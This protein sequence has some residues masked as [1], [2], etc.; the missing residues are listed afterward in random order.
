MECKV[1]QNSRPKCTSQFR[2]ALRPKCT[3]QFRCASFRCRASALYRYVKIPAYV[4]AQ[5]W[6]FHIPVHFRLKRK[7]PL[8]RGI[9]RG[10]KKR[11]VFIYINKCDVQFGVLQI[12]AM[13]LFVYEQVANTDCEFPLS[14]FAI[15][16]WVVPN[17]VVML[18]PI[19]QVS[20][21]S[22]EGFLYQL[23]NPIIVYISYTGNIPLI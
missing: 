9:G 19:T 4:Q 6:D 1:I 7:N 5:H 13:Q 12:T 21:F 23:R 8:C 15:S 16:V 20:Q 10:V 3:S 22:S 14:Y 18:Y 2:C 17:I 11:G